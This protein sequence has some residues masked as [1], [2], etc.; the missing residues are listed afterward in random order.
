MFY[1]FNDAKMELEIKK[2]RVSSQHWMD[3]RYTEEELSA[4]EQSAI[5]QSEEDIET[6]TA[7]KMTSTTTVSVFTLL[8]A[9]STFSVLKRL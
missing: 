4:I 8:L 3:C 7:P 9:F 6:S 5:V 2:P 1:K